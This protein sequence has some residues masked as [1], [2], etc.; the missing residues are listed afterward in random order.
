MKEF[1]FKIPRGVKWELIPDSEKEK[2]IVLT[3]DEA[4]LICQNLKKVWMA[5][6]G[7]FRIIG[8]LHPIS[9]RLHLDYIA[10]IQGGDKVLLCKTIKHF[11]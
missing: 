7:I 10:I 5:G 6:K 9:K 1:N 8:A 4:Y 3:P 2:D 11:K